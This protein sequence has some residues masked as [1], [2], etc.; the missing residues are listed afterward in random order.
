MMKKSAKRLLTG[1]TGALALCAMATPTA[2]QEWPKIQL[3]PGF[4]IEKVVDGL[5]FPTSLTWDDHGRMY[6]AEAGGAFLELDAP[7]RILRVE[8]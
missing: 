2:A 3:P 7:A 4:K 6:V 5:S 8:G 1:V